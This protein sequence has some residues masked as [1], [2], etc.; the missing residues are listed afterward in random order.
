[1]PKLAACFP[2][3]G[4]RYLFLAVA[5]AFMQLPETGFAAQNDAVLTQ[6]PAPLI[7]PYISD[8]ATLAQLDR[9]SNDCNQAGPLNF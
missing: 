1:M 9:R 8:P 5:L 6:I 4:C 7:G 2:L 3:G